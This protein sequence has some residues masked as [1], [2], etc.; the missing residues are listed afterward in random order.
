MGCGI[1]YITAN[2]EWPGQL[3]LVSDASLELRRG[4]KTEYLDMPLMPCS[5]LPQSIWIGGLRG[6]Q[7]LVSQNLSQSV[8]IPSNPYGLKITEQAVKDSIK[9]WC[10]EWVTM[11][12]HH[13]SLHARS[14]RHPDVRVPSWIEAPTDLEV[15]EA[16][17]L[18]AEIASFKDRDLTVEAVVIDFVFM[19]IEPLKDRVYPAY[20]YTGVNDSSRDTNIQISKGSVLKHVEKMLRGVVLNVG[21][22]RSYSAWNLPRW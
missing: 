17:V 9:G 15:V 18:L 7:S 2:L 13:K 19:N 21:S 12:N 8:S 11:E 14:R 22:P 16:R 20:I 3:E 1:I 5:V 6:V 4:R 10:F